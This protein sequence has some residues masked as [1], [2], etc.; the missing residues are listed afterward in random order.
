MLECHRHLGFCL[1]SRV[2]RSAQPINAVR[3]FGIRRQINVLSCTRKECD[4]TQALI[5]GNVQAA[6]LRKHVLTATQMIGVAGRTAHYVTPRGH[7]I[8]AVL[9]T[10][11][12]TK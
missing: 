7:D 1:A 11:L 6:M 4:E 10:H 2:P 12:A 8:A 3:N 9:I 5:T